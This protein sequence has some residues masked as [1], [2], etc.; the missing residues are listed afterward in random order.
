MLLMVLIMIIE[1]T[2]V[3]LKSK[4]AIFSEFWKASYYLESQKEICGYGVS[5]VKVSH[6]K[7]LIEE[8]KTLKVIELDNFESFL[9]Y[10][11]FDYYLIFRYNDEFYFCDTELATTYKSLI[12]LVDY[13][14]HLRKDKINKINENTTY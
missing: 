5:E 11:N 9:N 8:L 10:L 7:K 4:K 1:S 3:S 14:I 6:S 2:K 12:K 13:N